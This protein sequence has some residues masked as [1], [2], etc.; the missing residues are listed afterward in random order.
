[1]WKVLVLP[2]EP[3]WLPI[4]FV[5]YRQDGSRAVRHNTFIPAEMKGQRPWKRRKNEK[6]NTSWCLNYAT[7]PHTHDNE[8]REIKFAPTQRTHPRFTTLNH[9]IVKSRVRI[10]RHVKRTYIGINLYLCHAYAPDVCRYERFHSPSRV[11]V[12]KG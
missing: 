2:P 6:N 12:L 3:G 9:R 7:R 10:S 8:E 1:M 5:V 11:G 4:V